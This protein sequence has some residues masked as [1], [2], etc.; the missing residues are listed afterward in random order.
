MKKLKYILTIIAIIL[1]FYFTD[2]LMILVDNKNP[3]MQTIIKEETNYNIK[4]VNAEIKDNTIIP[5]LNGKK[6]NRHKS[7][8]KMEEFSK[9]NEIY[10]EYDEITPDISLKDNKDKIIVKG[11]KLKNKVALIVEEN[12][13]IENYLNDNNIKYSYITKLNSNLT[14]KREYINGEKEEKNFSNLNS[15]LNKNKINS[16]IC[17]INYYNIETCNSKKYYIVNTSLKI[18]NGLID[19]LNKLG[20]GDIILISS[21]LSLD[22]LKLLLNEINKQDLQIDYLS[23]VINE[24]IEN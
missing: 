23:K 10:L 8:I 19:S 24:N 4:P 16:K 17:L 14:L 5:G 2:K 15:L 3:L 7:L 21:S 11:N 20:S 22:N 13:L 9:F 1:S 6:V 18:N 12:T